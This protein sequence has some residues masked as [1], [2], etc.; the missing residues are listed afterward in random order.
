MARFLAGDCF[1]ACGLLS[2]K[3]LPRDQFEGLLQNFYTIKKAYGTGCIKDILIGSYERQD[4]W[5]R[6]SG[7]PEATLIAFILAGL[8][9]R[10]TNDGELASASAEAFGKYLAGVRACHLSAGGPPMLKPNG[11]VS[12]GPA[13]AWMDGYRIVEGHKVPERISPGWAL[14]LIGRNAVVELELQKYLLPEVN[15]RWIRC[16]EAGWLFS[17]YVRDFRLADR[18]RMIYYKALGSFKDTFYNAQAGFLYNMVTTDESSLGRRHDPAITSAG[19]AAAAILGMD[20]FTLR[21]LVGV[22][23]AAKERLLR[24]KW[25][26]PFGAAVMDGA[27]CA[28][29]DVEKAYGG[30]V[31]PG[32]TPY[33][34]RLLR[35]TG[36]TETANRVLEANLRH[37]MEESFVF[38]N[39]EIFSCD[40][41][42]VPSGEPIRWWS[43]WV[44]PY[45]E[46]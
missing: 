17:K 32:D 22:A 37:Q 28:Y 39:N 11:L 21:E 4:E 36:D 7:Q 18:C 13:L 15:A 27:E 26:T 25:D 1:R 6:C 12:V 16:L 29:L 14:E 44:D 34:V 9:V 46:S 38:Y 5:G 35:M 20:A 23:R 3:M 42:L 43:Q 19:V 10:E 45:L 8:V 30:A 2:G 33:L 40:H 24:K 31:C 41:D